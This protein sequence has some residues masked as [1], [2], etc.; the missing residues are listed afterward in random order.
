MPKI[1]LTNVYNLDG[2]YDLELVFTHRD[3]HTI[4][5][6]AGVRANEVMDSINAGDMDVL[7]ALAAIALRRANKQFVVNQLWD[8]EAGSITLDLTAEEQEAEANPPPIELEPRNGDGK[9]SGGET[10]RTSTVPSP[11]T[12][13]V[14]D[15]GTPEPVT[16]SDRLTS[17]I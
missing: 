3:F 13:P 9:S 1:V 7:V 8:T 4:K 6:I 15:S 17:T 11:E 16:D 14:L 5:Q 2:E 10:S 12:F